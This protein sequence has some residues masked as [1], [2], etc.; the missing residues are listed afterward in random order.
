MA[1]P[2]F[3]ASE[4]RLP[5]EL[6]EPLL[7]H[8]RELKRRYLERGWGARVG[9]GRRPAL[10]VIDLARYWTEPQQQIGTDLDSV[11]EAACRVLAAARA[12]EIPIFFT[13]F[14]YDPADPPSPQNIKLQMKLGQGAEALFEID[15]RVGKADP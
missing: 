2:A 9:F 5:D 12:A 7:K 4:L 8:L 6:R 1:G 3:G 15:P 13:T 14:A 11:V 10:I